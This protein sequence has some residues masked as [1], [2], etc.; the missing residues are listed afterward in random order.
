MQ[1]CVAAVV[2]G[3][4]GHFADRS[5]EKYIKCGRLDGFDISCDRS[6]FRNGFGRSNKNEQVSRLLCSAQL[7]GGAEL[8]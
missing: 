2:C 8:C 7:L 1:C 4:R 3:V 5:K 6:L